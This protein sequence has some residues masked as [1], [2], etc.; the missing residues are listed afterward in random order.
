MQIDS[1]AQQKNE[2]NPKFIDTAAGQPQ[3]IGRQ[4]RAGFQ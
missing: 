4:K 2:D 1:V 3:P